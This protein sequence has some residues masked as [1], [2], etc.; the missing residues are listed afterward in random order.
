[1]DAIEQIIELYNRGE[2]EAAEVMIN[3]EEELIKLMRDHGFDH[4][5]LIDYLI[6]RNA[7]DA[8]E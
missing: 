2:T 5:Q 6:A 7:G 4:G 3:A 8:D 1:M